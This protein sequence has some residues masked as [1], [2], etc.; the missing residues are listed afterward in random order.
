MTDE[1][2]QTETQKS[3]PEAHTAP[4]PSIPQ[5]GQT[6]GTGNGLELDDAAKRGSSARGKWLIVG[7]VVA[8][9]VASV[10]LYRHYAGWES[11][12]DAEIDGY[13]NPISSRVAG[14]ITKVTVNNND[15]VKAGQVLVQIDPTDYQV[16][17]ESARAAYENDL[18]M[19]RSM[20]ANVPVSQV[21]TSTQLSSASAGVSDAE[22]GLSA[23]EQQFDASQAGLRQSEANNAKAEDDVN[24]YKQLV[25]KQEISEQ[26][27]VQA[28]ETANGTAAAVAAARAS[29]A[30]AEKQ[31][32]QARQRV[33]QANAQLRYART[34]PR[35]VSITRDRAL[36]AQAVADKGKAQLDQAQLNLTYATIVAPVDGIV[37]QRSA[38]IGAYV[39]PGQALM[40]IVPLNDIWVTANFK[41]TQLL[42][43]R[44][45]QKAIIHVDAFDHDYNGHVLNIAGATG[46]L[47]SLLPPENAT[48]NYVKVVQR[49]P[50]R[51]AIDSGQDSGH[52]LRPG[53]S[54]EPRVRVK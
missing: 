42:N 13:I 10:F 18:A 3:Q 5:K 43:M 24:R 28:V 21:N 4:A 36:A 52:L 17:V 16:A 41:E 53:L 50:V 29:A 37:G 26:Q 46:S 44:P 32:A 1:R 11:T 39:Q 48:G 47:F 45:G 19:A 14:T 40:A 33:A 7:G 35:Q 9:A 20:M 2:V 25:S 22:A 34:G 8:L 23:A 30:V 6:A 54:V 31:V 12:D 49:V 15:S 27:Y 38:Q 51:I